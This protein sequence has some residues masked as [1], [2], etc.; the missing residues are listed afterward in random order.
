MIKVGNPGLKQEFNHNVNVGYNTFNILTFKFFAANINFNTTSN[1]IVNSTEGTGVQVIR[2][3]NLNGYYNVTS[4]ATFG[5]PFR[6]KLKGSSLNFTNSFGYN[7]D[8]SMVNGLKNIGKTLTAMGGTGI[9]F[10]LFKEALDFGLNANVTYYNVQYSVNKNMNEDYFAQ[11]YSADLTLELP[12]HIILSSDFDYYINSG[13]SN[14]FNQ[15]IPLWNA[16]LAKQFLKAKNA[17][18]KFS[19]NDIL[20][21]NQ[22]ITRTTQDNY[23]E[24]SRAV[25]L[26][27]YFLVSFLYN[28][29]KMGGKNANPMQGMPM[30]KMIERGM[31]NIR[32][33]Q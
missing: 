25:V 29:N 13:R 19:V 16:G 4:F 9:N 32:I 3:I 6:K 26:R 10:N 24:D 33:T 14:G 28:L 17:E 23:I 18:L 15:Q 5:I 20:N 11:T 21:Q 1:K 30:P 7:N 22:S 8:V 12:A 31:K 27:R 2:P